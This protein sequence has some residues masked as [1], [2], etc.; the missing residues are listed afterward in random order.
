MKFG[1]AKI[2]DSMPE[3]RLQSK[4]KEIK[5]EDLKRLIQRGDK[6]FFGTACSEPTILT[7]EMAKSIWQWADVEVLHFFTVSNTAFCNEKNPTEYRHNSISIVGSPQMRAAIKKGQSDYTPMMSSQIPRFL[8]GIGNRIRIDVALIQCTPPDKNGLCSL[9]INVD[10]NRTVVD[11]ARTVIAQINPLMPRT[12][13]DSFIKFSDIDHYIYHESPIT[14]FEPTHFDTQPKSAEDL[15]IIEKIAQNA[16]DLIENDTTLDLGFGKIQY[17]IPK[18]LLKKQNLAIYSEMIQ[19]SVIPLI[20]QGVVNCQK[21]YYPHCMTSMALGTKKFYDFVHDNPFIEFHPT[22]YICN[23]PRIAKNHQMCSVY[24]ATK[25]D[26]V[27]QVSNHKEMEVLLG[28]GGEADFMRGCALTPRGRSIVTLPSR[29]PDGSSNILVT[30]SGYPLDLCAYDV[31][32]VVT[33][34]GI[35]YLHGKTVRERILQMIGIAHPDFREALLQKAK[36]VKMV[37]EDQ[38]IPMT[39]DGVVVVYPNRKWRYVSP[40]K[41]EMYFR[42]IKIT[43]ERGIQELYYG[44]SDQDRYLRFFISMLQF[45]HKTIQKGIVCDYQ[46]HFVVV[47]I[48]GEEEEEQLISAGMYFL[49]KDSALADVAFTVNANYRKHGIARKMLYLMIDYGEEHGLKGFKGEYLL[50]NV[51][52]ARLFHTIPYDVK[53]HNHGDTMEFSFFFHDKISEKNI[54]KGI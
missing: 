20:Q 53:F 24:S 39:K 9:G 11:T 15:D 46:N 32:F 43:D 30:L 52:I 1:Q 7:E 29:A 12:M 33:E 41:L 47:G 36:E 48:I 31:H 5:P 49:D 25:V 38:Q 21:N 14:E 44:L 40:Q 2:E 26:L 45:P 27:G 23:L 13:G 8:L 4:A 50:S 3:W 54:P 28:L 6:V 35:A 51:G 19:E 10:V 18:Y 17:S 42:P 16:A 37:Y 34:Y 22:E